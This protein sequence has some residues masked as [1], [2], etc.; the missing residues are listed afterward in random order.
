MIVTIKID[1]YGIKK[2]PCLVTEYRSHLPHF[3]YDPDRLRR[4]FCRGELW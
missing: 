2:N 3:W 1:F 4:C